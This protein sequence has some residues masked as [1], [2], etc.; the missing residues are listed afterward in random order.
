MMINGRSK[1]I[2]FVC[3][4]SAKEANKAM[5]SMNGRVISERPLYV[6][7]AERKDDRL[8]YLRSNFQRYNNTIDPVCTNISNCDVMH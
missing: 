7:I 4:S 2:G 5:A 3:F 1:G 6:S 8:S